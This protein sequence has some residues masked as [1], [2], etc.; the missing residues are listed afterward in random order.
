MEDCLR[1]GLIIQVADGVIPMN[2]YGV[3]ITVYD[4]IFPTFLPTNNTQE[5]Q[6]PPIHWMDQFPIYAPC[7][8][9]IGADP[10][11]SKITFQGRS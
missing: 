10:F 3:A 4:E 9:S 1:I 2:T 6:T 11:L 7:T 5:C 8:E